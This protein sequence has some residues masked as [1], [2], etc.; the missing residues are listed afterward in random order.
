MPC[1]VSLGQHIFIFPDVLVAV[2][3]LVLLL[4]LLILLAVVV[5][6]LLGFAFGDDLLGNHVN[7]LLLRLAEMLQLE[8]RRLAL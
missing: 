5:E 3:R 8:L 2:L 7:G 6:A 1:V 4:P